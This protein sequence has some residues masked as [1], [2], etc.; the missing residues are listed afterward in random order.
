[1][2]GRWTIYIILALM[3]LPT[4]TSNVVS[5][6]PFSETVISATESYVEFT[7]PENVARRVMAMELMCY[8]SSLTLEKEYEYCESTAVTLSEERNIKLQLRFHHLPPPGLALLNGDDEDFD[9]QFD[10]NEEAMA[11]DAASMHEFCKAWDWS[12][13]YL[14]F[15]EKY[16]LCEFDDDLE[17][18]KVSQ[19]PG[20]RK[21]RKVQT[22]K[23][24]KKVSV[25]DGYMVLLGYPGAGFFVNLKVE[26]SKPKR[27][28]KDKRN[29]IESL[30]LI[31]GSERYAANA[32]RH[33]KVRGYDYYRL[34][35]NAIEGP[36]ELGMHVFFDDD[37]QIV[38]TMYFLDQGPEVRIF[39]TYDEYTM[40]RDRFLDR[41]FDC[42]QSPTPLKFFNR[43]Q[44]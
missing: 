15:L 32:L 1:M 41:Y 14:P 13:S 38:I 17:I 22:S 6:T 4:S 10:S 25:R 35:K 26:K 7:I 19:W 37:E 20:G 29:I 40:L 31:S 28:E 21:H 9:T 8:C 30:R 18:V 36:D 39:S 5:A 12:V 27:Y 11:V 2:M 44:E 33:A 16:T 42:V 34:D 43:E 23:G 24:D 3:A